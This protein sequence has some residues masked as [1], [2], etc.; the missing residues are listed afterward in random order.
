MN[1]PWCQHGIGKT[2]R[3]RPAPPGRAEGG[4]LHLRVGR[5]VF[6]GAQGLGLVSVEPQ[7]RHISHP[8][9][10]ALAPIWTRKGFGIRMTLMCLCLSVTLLHPSRSKERLSDMC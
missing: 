3:R 1:M 8:D 5:C 10:T 7:R 9:Y 4:E 2:R 6:S